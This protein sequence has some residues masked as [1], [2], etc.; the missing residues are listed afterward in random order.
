M[1]SD[2]I[3]QNSKVSPKKP[4]R[5]TKTSQ[6]RAQSELKRLQTITKD[7]IPDTMRSVA[8]PLL[9]NI[10][11]QKV[12]LDEA[13]CDL[14]YE[15]LYCEYNNG[16]GQHGIRE[17]PG[18]SAYNKLFTTFSRGIKQLTDLMEYDAG[19]VDELQEYFNESRIE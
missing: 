6:E 9:H 12:K 19:E 3:R 2:E 17:H 5:R 13:R 16:G 14:M 1:K 15:S 7:A 8:M 4:R 10:A 18:F 11:W